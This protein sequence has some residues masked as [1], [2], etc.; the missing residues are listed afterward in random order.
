MLRRMNIFRKVLLIIIML[1]VPILFLYTYLYNTSTQ[2]IKDEIK[3]SSLNK[4]QFLMS[5]V[6]LTLN[7]LSML[8]VIVSRDPGVKNYGLSPDAATTLDQVKQETAILDSLILQSASNS[9]INNLTVYYPHLNKTISTDYFIS[10]S[11][12]QGKPFSQDWS[13]ERRTTGRAS[14]DVFVRHA[15]EPGIAYS[16]ADKANY[17]IEVEFSDENLVNMLNQFKHDDKGHSFLYYKGYNPIAGRFADEAKVQRIVEYLDSEPLSEIGNAVVAVGDDSYLVN[18]VR[19]RSLDWYF[20]DY[21]ALK[22]IWR[23]VIS[24]R[25]LF[26]FSLAMLLTLSVFAAFLLYRNVQ[27]PIRK[28]IKSTEMVAEG[29][30][31]IRLQTGNSKDFDL[32]FSRFN[33]MAARIQ[34]LIEHVYE[35][36][37]RTREASLKQLQS[38]INPH[39]LYNSLFFIKNMAA[40]GDHDAVIAMSLN[41][42]EYYR[43]S[44]R[45]DQSMA[46]V[47]EEMQLIGNYLLIQNLRLKRLKYKLDIPEEMLELRLPR[48]LIQPLVEN[49]IVHGVELKQGEAV[50]NVTGFREGVQYRIVVEDN[51]PGMEE[52]P[53]Q[54]LVSS[55]D[56]KESDAIGC[57]LWNVH[58]RLLHLYGTDA[59]LRISRSG[60]GGLRVEALWTVDDREEER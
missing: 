5:Q 44:T 58:Q 33:D 4:L 26:Y 57:G 45:L 42:G 9:W 60:L 38:Q 28:L 11:D 20:V 31:V 36:K 12:L 10:A 6:E 16:D 50:V 30:Y 3:S 27:M 2:V 18:Y 46:S 37:L 25:N 47:G 13:H 7:Q 19:S 41:L 32:L 39:F 56:K 55:L 48:L 53:L 1:L 15:L 14:R 22:Q 35:E 51:G 34:K 23:P 8:A 52:G 49:A 17:A 40:I 24:S 21:V 29:Q 59:G 43:Y 54:Q